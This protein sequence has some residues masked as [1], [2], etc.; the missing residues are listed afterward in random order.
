MRQ[1]ALIYQYEKWPL[2]E[3][4]AKEALQKYECKINKTSHK[5]LADVFRKFNTPNQ[6]TGEGVNIVND[7]R[8]ILPYLSEPAKKLANNELEIAIQHQSKKREG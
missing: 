8:T 5:K 3:G 4:S 2:T 7:I 6:R 1:I